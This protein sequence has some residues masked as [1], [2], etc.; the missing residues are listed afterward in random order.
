MAGPIR[1]DQIFDAAIRV[2]SR[3]G[4]KRTRM[5]DIAAE[6]DVV[7]GTLYRHCKGKKDLYEKA[8]AFGIQ[9]WQAKVKAHVASAPDAVTG[10]VLMCEKGHE[11]LAEDENLRQILKRGPLTFSAFPQEIAVSSN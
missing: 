6:L 7:A 11:Y 9:R 10:F 4:F 8:V 1:E 3:Y 5:E 2:F